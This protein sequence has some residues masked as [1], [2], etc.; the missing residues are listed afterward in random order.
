MLSVVAPSATRE[1][2]LQFVAFAQTVRTLEADD[3]NFGRRIPFLC[4]QALS[5]AVFLLEMYPA[6]PPVEVLWRAFPYYMLD[7]IIDGGGGATAAAA[8]GQT[9]GAP[10]VQSSDEAA[11]TAAVAEGGMMFAMQART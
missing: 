6:L 11:G 1:K 10:P 8:A 4:D 7:S 3:T 5:R 9:P 2:L